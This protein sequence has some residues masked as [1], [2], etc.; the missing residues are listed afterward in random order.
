MDLFCKIEKVEIK[1][2]PENQ[3]FDIFYKDKY[4]PKKKQDFLINL[5]IINK[6]D[7]IIENGVSNFLISGQND[8]GKYTLAKYF[9]EKYFEN[10]CIIRKYTFVNNNKELIYYKSIYHYELHIDL[11]NCNIINLVQSF[12]QYIVRPNNSGLNKNVILIKNVHLLKPEILNLF[13]IYLDKYYNNIF[14][15]IG[16]KFIN[17]LKGFFFNLRVPAPNNK[18][19][20]K[21]LKK[22]IKC[23]SIKIK[24][25][26]LN[27]II[28]KG[29]RKILKTIS[30]LENCF[31]NGTF[32][33][34]FDSNE[35]IVHLIFKIVKNPNIEGMVKIRDYLNQLLV[36]NLSIYDI[37]IL[38]KKK[39]EN[40]KKI[41]M[42]NKIICIEYIKDCDYGFVKGYREL[43]HLEYCLIRIINLLKK[44]WKS[45]N[46]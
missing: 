26:E 2:N 36:N 37:N 5:N 40:E 23:E 25:K 43:H 15:F 14:I 41:N 4:K 21:L 30:L 29:N 3:K 42:N 46:I 27:Y 7:S 38:L 12:L 44:T 19:I 20:T 9:I 34:Y 32:E 35:K 18:E 17:Y 10:P 28:E 45:E 13:K 24:K 6:L 11:H 22:I 16:K 39:I 31:I 8:V 33:E 1:T